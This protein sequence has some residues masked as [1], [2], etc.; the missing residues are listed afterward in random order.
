MSEKAKLPR[1]VALVLEL[2]PKESWAQ[3]LVN[4]VNQF[5]LEVV[6]AL[7]VAQVQY[8]TLT[9]RTGEDVT[10]AFPIDFPVESTPRDVR[11]AGIPSGD[12][13][14]LSAITVKWQPIVAQGLSV[15]VQY[16]TGL[17]ANTS[18]T[19]RLAYQ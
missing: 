9:F 5:A 10:A 7:R 6:Q 8:K 15:R 4:A 2:F 1:Q 19:V 17:T 14:G 11:I 16:I 12:V 18:Y 3:T 13:I